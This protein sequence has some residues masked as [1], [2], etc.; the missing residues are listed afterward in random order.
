MRAVRAL[1]ATLAVA[2]IFALTGCGPVNAGSA[3]ADAFEQEYAGMDGVASVVAGGSNDLPFTGSVDATV[4]TDPGLSDARVD[5]IAS[6]LSEYIASH[7]GIGWAVELTADRVTAGISPDDSS[8]AGM[9]SAARELAALPHVE[10]ARVGV[11]YDEQ[12]VLVEVDAPE[13]LAEGYAAADA[14]AERLG[15]VEGRTNSRAVH[16]PD[17]AF[18]VDDESWDGETTEIT[19]PLR[20]YEA[21]LTRFALISARITPDSIILRAAHEEDVA[22]LESFVAA[23]PAAG[24]EIE[25]QGGKTTREADATPE[26]DAVASA[27]R[28]HPEVSTIHASGGH[29]SVVLSSHAAAEEVLAAAEATPGFLALDGF[30]LREGTRFRAVDR[31]AD[32]AA[33]LEIAQAAAA[34]T[35]VTDVDASRLADKASPELQLR[36]DSADESVISDLAASLKPHLVTGGWH[37]WFNADGFVESFHAEDR[38]VLEPQVTGDRDKVE[39]DF[40]D[41]LVRVWNQAAG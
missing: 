21:A 2:V 23:I 28:E 26:A 12:A 24:L 32:F 16:G 13:V 31:P 27:L 34:L 15:F 9:L 4:T 17:E 25:I 37:V 29:V 3:A 20:I 35:A 38:I 7:S 6:D 30:G 18:V 40:A 33:T 41:M 36:F 1:S 5:E 22:P 14:V 11:T 39:Q 10:S 8:T 19:L